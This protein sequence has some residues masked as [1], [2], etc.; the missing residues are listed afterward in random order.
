MLKRI[1]LFLIAAM[2]S[3][4]YAWAQDIS[5]PR[6]YVRLSAGYGFK[7]FQEN[8][9]D[10]FFLNGGLTIYP[11]QTINL[12]QVNTSLG[13]GFSFNAGYCYMFSDNIGF[14]AGLTLL[15]GAKQTADINLGIGELNQTYQGQIIA[16]T[17]ALVMAQNFS[18]VQVY[19][20]LGLILATGRINFDYVSDLPTN[21]SISNGIPSST[22]ADHTDAK[23]RYS[24]GLA[25]GMNIAAGVSGNLTQKLGI[26]AELNVNALTYAPTKGKVLSDRY[27][28]KNAMDTMT[29][30]QKQINFKNSIDA[31]N[32]GSSTVIGSQNTSLNPNSPGEDLRRK[33]PFGSV[34]IMIG[35]RFRL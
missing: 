29:T 9:P 35:V 22:G 23:C 15:A 18:K 28:G 3:C 25:T 6:T 16:L 17:P 31:S 10:R 33:Y 14:D 34:G 5:Q 1:F 2:F 32:F 27:N 13:Q 12:K 7:A 19:T 30:S 8:L 11:T 4:G 26:F 21:I 24:G 20:R